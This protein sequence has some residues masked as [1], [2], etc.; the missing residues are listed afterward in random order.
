[1]IYPCLR[2]TAKLIPRPAIITPINNNED[3]VSPVLGRT[4]FV[5]FFPKSPSDLVIDLLILSSFNFVSNLFLSSNDLLGLLPSSVGFVVPDDAL[6]SSVGFIVPNGTLPS[7]VGFIVPDGAL[8]S[9][10]G[11]IV[12]D[13]LLPS[14]VGFIV[15]DRLF[16]VI[17]A[18]AT[19]INLLA[20]ASAYDFENVSELYDKTVLRI[21]P[22]SGFSKSN[23]PIVNR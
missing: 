12:P 13:G 22:S 3:V 14:S 2:F 6:P 18:S 11:F 15:P 1:M 19:A 7:S 8:P 21:Y 9:S 16:P 4:L 23:G 17:V 20:N 10:A 5:S